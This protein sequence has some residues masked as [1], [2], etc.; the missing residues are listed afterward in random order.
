[1]AGKRKVRSLYLVETT[2][3][4]EDAFPLEKGT[5]S[6]TLPL[7]IILV[8]SGLDFTKNKYSFLINR[9]DYEGGTALELQLQQDQA[10]PK[11]PYTGKP[12][13]VR[14]KSPQW[15]SKV[16]SRAIQSMS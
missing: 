15:M 14:L 2:K 9:F 7:A 11:A 5:K 1:M 8:K 12:R 6:Y 4:Q 10:A 3:S 13:G 16:I